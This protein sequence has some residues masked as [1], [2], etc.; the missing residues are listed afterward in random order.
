M[1]TKGIILFGTFRRCE[2][3]DAL[4]EE[5]VRNEQF[6]S[7]YEQDYLNPLDFLIFSCNAVKIGNEWSPISQWVAVYSS[8]NLYAERWIAALEEKEMVSLERMTI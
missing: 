8:N 4:A 7:R 5:L 6:R 3:H 1:I 2:N